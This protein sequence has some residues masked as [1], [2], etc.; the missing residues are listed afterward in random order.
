MESQTLN[1]KEYSHYL[2]VTSQ[3][4][5]VHCPWLSVK[6]SSDTDGTHLPVPVSPAGTLSGCSSR[7]RVTSRPT[8]KSLSLPHVPLNRERRS[9]GSAS[10]HDSSVSNVLT[11]RGVSLLRHTTLPYPN[12]RTLQ[13]TRMEGQVRSYPDWI[14]LKKPLYR[15]EET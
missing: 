1:P 14:D 5:S 4:S 10:E 9:R 8:L 7:T 11:F 6:L 12:I 3:R 13:S 15:I 2:L